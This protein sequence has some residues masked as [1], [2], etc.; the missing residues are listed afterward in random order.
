MKKQ[1]SWELLRTVIRNVK[2]NDD[3]RN[4]N[5]TNKVIVFIQIVI[6]LWWLY[7]GIEKWNS[8]WNGKR[9]KNNCQAYAFFM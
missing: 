2:N 6:W 9:R 7:V 8:K 1:L 4:R 5:K 3:N